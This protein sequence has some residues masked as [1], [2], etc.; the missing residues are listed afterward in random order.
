MS[1]V[2]IV[3]LS[4]GSD[5]TVYEWVR[6]DRTT[7]HVVVN[8][9]EEMIRPCDSAGNPVGEMLIR[10]SVGNAEN[11]DPAT[12]GRFL[13]VAATIFQEWSKVGSLPQTI[14]RNFG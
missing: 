4:S 13:V 11:P 12:R 2:R 9:A 6:D 5:E 10:K 8:E 1:S 3:K 14:S 7:G